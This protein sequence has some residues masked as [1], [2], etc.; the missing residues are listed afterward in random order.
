MPNPLHEIAMAD[1]DMA[2]LVKHRARLISDLER[3]AEL[4]EVR[5]V[6]LELPSALRGATGPIISV[7]LIEMRHVLEDAS[8]MDV[9]QWEIGVHMEVPI[10]RVSA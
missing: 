8:P 3:Y 1:A 10:V 6:Y 7:D 5:F 9:E 2:K 4:L